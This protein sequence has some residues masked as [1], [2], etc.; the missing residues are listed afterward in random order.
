MLSNKS[1][2]VPRVR[3]VAPSRAGIFRVFGRDSNWKIRINAEPA[4]R[5]F[6]AGRGTLWATHA[7]SLP[8][9]TLV[10]SRAVMYFA[11]VGTVVLSLGVG[12]GSALMLT[13]SGPIQKE[14]PAAFANREL[15]DIE[16]Q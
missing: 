3:P 6:A 8:E 4:R 15:P 7:F 16:E 11:G 5:S 2:G 14:Q 13:R 9:E 12:F 10:V 1:R